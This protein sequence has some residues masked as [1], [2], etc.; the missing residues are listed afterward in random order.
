MLRGPRP[1]LTAG[2]PGN[3]ASSALYVVP[4]A[5]DLRLQSREFQDL[6]IRTRG[7]GS[8]DNAQGGYRSLILELARQT[9]RPKILEI[10]GGRGPF[11]SQEDVERLQC[12]YTVNDIDA[13]ELALAPAW[14]KRLHGDIADPALLDAAKHS[15]LYDLAF[16]QMVFE[17]VEHPAQGYRNIVQLLAPGGILVNL[18]PTLYAAPFVINKLLPERLSA[19][20]LAWGFPHRNSHESPKFPAFY[21]WCT[22]TKRTKKKLDSVGFRDSRIVPFYGHGYYA[23]IPILGKVAQHFWPVAERHDWRMLSTYAYII[24]ET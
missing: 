23:K 18:V 15:G 7:A 14:V 9:D 20:V 12:E 3:Q 22:T 1:R 4:M 5:S 24:C 16:S 2:H 21:R 13:S 6:I 11:L 17:H 8:S 10:G 19:R